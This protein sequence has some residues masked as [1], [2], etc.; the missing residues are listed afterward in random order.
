MMIRMIACCESMTCGLP[1]DH[2]LSREFK[3]GSINHSREMNFEA[4]STYDI[5]DDQFMG[6]MKFEKA[7]DGS[8]IIKAKRTQR[9]GQVH[10]RVKEE[11]EIRQMKGEVDPQ[12][13]L[14]PQSGQLRA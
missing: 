14:D 12:G 2:F 9:Q 4:P 3:D 8:W 5:Y 11:V 7:L 1:C 10:P 13:G 6:M